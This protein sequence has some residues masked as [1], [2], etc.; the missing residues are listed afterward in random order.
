MKK[1]ALS[2]RQP[3]AWLLVNGIKDVENRSWNPPDPIIGKR[4]YIHAG[5]AK[6][7]KDDFEFWSDLALNEWGL[8]IFPKSREDLN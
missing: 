1:L 4:I 3:Y 2:I 5:K 7:S 8:K 6:V